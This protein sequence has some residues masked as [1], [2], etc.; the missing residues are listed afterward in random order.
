MH[1]AGDIADYCESH[2][3][4]AR[5]SAHSF[6]KHAMTEAW[7]LKIEPQRAAIAYGCNVRAMMAHYVGLDEAVAE[8]VMSEVQQPAVREAADSHRKSRGSAGVP[9][10]RGRIRV[11]GCA[12]ANPVIS[13]LLSEDDGTRT[14]NHRIDSRVVRWRP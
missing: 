10:R 9:P 14:R 13:A 3:G 11:C 12:A 7:K 6:R 2:P 5:C 4:V 1:A 8:A